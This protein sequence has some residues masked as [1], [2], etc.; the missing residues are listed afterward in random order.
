MTA[1]PHVLAV[2]A[3][4]FQQIV[5]DGSRQRPV[6]VDFWASWCA[7]CR[8][9]LPIL[10]KLAGEYGG[11]LLVA[12][13]N[14]DEQQ[15]L[16]S[17]FG[18]R[19]LPTVQLFREGQ[20]VDQFLGALPESQVRDFLERHLPR[21]SDALIARATRLLESGALGEAE[22]LLEQARRL[23]PDNA[24]LWPAEALALAASGDTQGA[25]EKLARVPLELAQD[26]SVL[27]LRGRLHFV[28]LVA[29]APAEMALEARLAADPRDP[30]ARHLAAAHCAA[31]GDY[32]AALEHLLQL[33]KYNR[34]YGEE[35]A[36]K[37]M[38][39]LFDLLGGQGELVSSYRAKMLNALY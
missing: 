27:A 20:M 3:E 38:L 17:E 19:S 24:R 34:H 7:P 2:T 39:R 35:A 12:K 22:A 36:R 32:A 13:V 25:E 23:D 16:A 1:S 37:D 4:T 18:I 8:A 28:N 5:L 30:E 15:A 11:R 21:E 33:L 10:T 6:L 9:L 29:G 14:T 31:R 26:P